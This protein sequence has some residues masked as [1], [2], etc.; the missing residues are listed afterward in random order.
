MGSTY[1]Q[2]TLPRNRRLVEDI[3]EAQ[4]RLF[5]KLT[6]LDADGIDLSDYNRGYLKRYQAKLR[7]N[8][9][10]FG[11]ILAWALSTNTKPLGDTVLLEY[12]GGL[13]ILSLLA[14]EAGV[15]TVIYNDIYDVSCV[16][17]ETIAVLTKNHA[18]HYICGDL[19]DIKSFLR[20]QSLSCD[21]VVCSDVIE[22]V[23]DIDEFLADLQRLSNGPLAV[24]MSTH[25]NPLN[26]VLRRALAKKQIEV[27]LE[28]RTY[29]RDHK[30]RDSLESYL[31]L[32][33]KIIRN[34]ASTLN[35]DEVD[36]LAAAT[37]GMIDTDIRKAV[38]IYAETK[39]MPR[40]PDHPTNTCDPRTGNWADRLLHPAQLSESFGE[41]GFDVDI[42]S[43]Y[44]GTPDGFAKRLIAP[45]LD[46]AIRV[47]RRQGLRLAPYFV[48]RGLADMT[49]S[50]IPEAPQPAIQEYHKKKKKKKKG[51]KIHAPAA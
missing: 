17:A 2:A 35:D 39:I 13:G 34:C 28:D 19:K 43:G 42:L 40:T 32:R 25:A 12:G 14:A 15:G 36:R 29:N 27:E 7:S 10:K 9:Q 49:G 41:A 30:K 23:Y 47:F 21:A 3:S 44:Y 24:A 51:K 50:Q 1:N 31:S 48:L 16:D 37:R 26:P 8:L 38:L 45:L 33:K 5:D 22:H 4:D 20:E 6:R 11:Y 18:Q 46:T